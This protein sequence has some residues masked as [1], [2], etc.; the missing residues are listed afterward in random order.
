MRV[1]DFGPSC[2]KKYFLMRVNSQRLGKKREKR[3][4]RR[5]VEWNGNRA[6]HVAPWLL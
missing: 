3:D 5:A 2:I 1:G 4:L 6:Q